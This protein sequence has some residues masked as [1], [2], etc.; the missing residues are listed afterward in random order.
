M[1]ERALW[2]VT[3]ML[4]V[5]SALWLVAFSAT[6]SD[7]QELSAIATPHNV[8]PG[9]IAQSQTAH[10]AAATRTS[11]AVNPGT[12]RAIVI[13]FVGGFVR[14]DDT[15]HP[16]VQL[17]EELRRRYT[18]SIYVE[19]FGNHDREAAHRQV[20]QWLDTNGNGALTADEKRKARIILYGHSWGASEVVTLA[21]ELGCR[22]VPVLLTI[23]VDS[24]AKPREQDGVIPPN[25]VNAV[26]FYQA[27]GIVH[28]RPEIVA[29]DP[30]QTKILGNFRMTYSDQTITSTGSPWLARLFM[31]P[32]IEIEDDPKVWQ[33][34][35]ELID[36]QLAEAGATAHPQPP[37]SSGVR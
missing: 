26:N 11:G 12:G 5:W 34:V 18:S 13:G 1:R 3:I 23:Q 14:A 7:A 30:S 8:I 6:R 25:V 4:L 33:R 2:M 19:V 21:R 37:A 27:D 24:V 36:K 31:K 9:A 10:E 28:G 32:H 17:V 22:K 35:T 20:L 29:A 16:E 15:R